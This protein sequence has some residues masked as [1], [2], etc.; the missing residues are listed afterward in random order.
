[1]GKEFKFVVTGDEESTLYKAIEVVETG[2]YRV[3][4]DSEDDSISFTHYLPE[5]VE[6]YLNEG[7]WV[8]VE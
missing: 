6:S 8:V 4:W 1:M 7:D 2:V 5:H 3:E